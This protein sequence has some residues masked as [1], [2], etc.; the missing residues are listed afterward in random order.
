MDREFLKKA[1]RMLH[2][3]NQFLLTKSP[4]WLHLAKTLE[5]ELYLMIDKKGG[6]QDAG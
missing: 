5:Q 1:M 6:D 4:E 3:Q 2:A